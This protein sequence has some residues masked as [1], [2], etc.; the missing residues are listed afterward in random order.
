MKRLDRHFAISDIHGCG[1]T[2]KKLVLEGVQL[3]KNDTLYLLGDYINKGP[4]SKEVLDFIFQ[5][6]KDGFHII[7]LRGNHEQYL[8]DALGSP[9]DEDYFLVR[10]GKETLESFGVSSTN[11]IPVKYLS[12]IQALPFYYSLDNYLLIHAG[13]NFDLED[14]YSD[15]FS[16][17]NIR[18]MTVELKK[19]GD[20][21]II[22]GH[23][24][25]SFDEIK[26][27]LGFQNNHISIDGGCVYH[28]IHALN[29]LV[30]LEIQSKKLY[31]QI[32][33]D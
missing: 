32:N 25:T 22:H 12:F 26:Q 1:N 11:E 2:F 31:L 13:L 19:T 28:H 29:H 5:L 20:R 16:M 6:Q 17:L 18:E 10:G 14:P 27:N 7:C 23:V 24:P 4:K 30:A 3:S 9:G 15:D 33:I 8:I 21:K